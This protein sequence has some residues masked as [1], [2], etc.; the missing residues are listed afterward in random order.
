MTDT[1]TCARPNAWCS[2]CGKISGAFWKCTSCNDGICDSCVM[3]DAPAYKQEDL[4]SQDKPRLTILCIG[5][6]NHVCEKCLIICYACVIEKNDRMGFCP[7]CI[8]SYTV[9][10]KQES[11]RHGETWW[12]CEEHNESA[13]NPCRECAI[14]AHQCSSC[15]YYGGQA[16]PAICHVCKEH[17]WYECEFHAENGGC[18]KC[19]KECAYCKRHTTRPAQC[20]VCETLYACASC[21]L[22]DAT[23]DNWLAINPK[24][25]KCDRLMC[26]G[27]VVTCYSC[28]RDCRDADVFCCECAPST[29]SEVGCSQHT[30]FKCANHLCDDELLSCSECEEKVILAESKMAEWTSEDGYESSSESECDQCETTSG[31]ISYPRHWQCFGPG[32]LCAEHFIGILHCFDCSRTVCRMCSAFC[33]CGKRLC[34]ECHKSPTHTCMGAELTDMRANR[35]A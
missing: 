2:Y 19:M 8:D 9:K 28:A 35:C 34:P 11:C 5:C 30:W 22:G 16:Y 18:L 13:M 24:C 33:S 29:L 14:E 6:W 20:E 27:C 23:I 32:M 3:N 21:A 10:R 4:E 25:G 1:T 26:A 31:L 15:A 12:A 7:Q 17:D